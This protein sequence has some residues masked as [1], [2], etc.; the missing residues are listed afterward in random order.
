LNKKIQRTIQALLSLIFLLG[1]LCR[2]QADKPSQAGQKVSVEASEIDVSSFPRFTGW[3]DKSGRNPVDYFVDAC[4]KHE[5]V[6]VGEQHYIKDYCE[7]FKQA[8]PAVYEKAGVRV[9][10]LEVCNAESNEKI[11]RLIEGDRYDEALAYEIARAENWGLWGYK[12]YWDILEA[13]WSLNRSLPAGQEHMRVVGIDREMDY[14]LDSLWR[15]DK[16]KDQVLIEKAKNQPD[17]YKRDDWLAENIEKGILAKGARG[18]VLVGLNHSFTHY[19][20]PIIDKEGKLKSEWPRMGNILYQKYGEKIFQ[21][22]LHGPYQSPAQIDKTYK[23][24]GPLWSD[25]IEKIMVARGNR[26][27]GFDVVGSPFAVVRDSRS[28]YFH[29]QPKV[30]FADLNRG[31]IFLK[32]VKALEPC[33]WMKDFVSD[34]MFEKSRDFYEF[35]Y[36]RKFKDSREVNE[37]FESGLKTL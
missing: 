17:I 22:G 5:L 3:L 15:A 32:P 34:E 4:R 28:Y 31:F 7:L 19:A 16:L 35:S 21:I 12:E 9:V 14:Q 2:A 36:G 8:L 37:F 26:P 27:V 11:A 24:E 10:A 20:Q 30:T 33:S 1:G 13:V 6:I 25:L 29:W 23:G 18:I